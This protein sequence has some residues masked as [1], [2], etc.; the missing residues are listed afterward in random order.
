MLFVIHALTALKIF[1]GFLLSVSNYAATLTEY[2]RRVHHLRL[3]LGLTQLDFEHR[4]VKIVQGPRTELDYRDELLGETGTEIGLRFCTNGQMLFRVRLTVAGVRQRQKQ[5]EA[6]AEDLDKVI[7]FH[8]KRQDRIANEMLTLTRSLKE[9]SELANRIIRKDTE[10]VGQSMQLTERNFS[11]LKEE[12]ETLQEHSR[13]SC[14]CWMWIILLTV[15]AVF[16]CKPLGSQKQ[17]S[18]RNK[19]VLFQ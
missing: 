17:P 14:K 2:E 7:D 13:R 16:V 19:A 4:A 18:Y 15:M 3:V 5:A 6:R 8:Q 10:T 9:Q 12:S 11:K 1:V